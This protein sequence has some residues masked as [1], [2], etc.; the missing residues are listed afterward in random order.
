MRH[1]GFFNLSLVTPLRR[2]FNE[3]HEGTQIEPAIPQTRGAVPGGSKLRGSLAS[4]SSSQAPGQ[5]YQDYGTLGPEGYLDLTRKWSR[6][7]AD[8]RLPYKSS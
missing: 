3:W 8:R 5:P 6:R 4:S 1:F 7:L 2:S